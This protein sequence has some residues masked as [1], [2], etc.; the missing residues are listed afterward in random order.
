MMRF[1]MNI[2]GNGDTNGDGDANITLTHAGTWDSSLFDIAA[3][4]IVQLTSL[5]FASNSAEGVMLRAAAWPVSFAMRVT[6]R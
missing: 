4:S 5:N 6:S 3:L 1:A 2:I